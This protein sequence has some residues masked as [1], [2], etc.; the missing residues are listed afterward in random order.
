MN[1][2]LIDRAVDLARRLQQRASGLQTAAERRQQSELDRM[3]QTPTDKA[4]LVQ[5]TD[6][7]FRPRHAARVAEQITHILDVQGVPRFFNPVDRALMR[8]FQTFGGWLP[9]VA[10][11][12]V[13][14]QMRQETANVVLPAETE[15]LTKHLRERALEGVRMNL[16]FLGEALLGESEAQHR[17]EKYLAALQLPEVE[18]MSVKISTIFSQINPLGRADTLRVLCERLE[19]LFRAAARARYT[20]ADGTQVAKFVYLDMEEYRDLHL[21]AVAFMRTLDRPGLEQ[22][23]AGVALQ[24][25]I[26]DSARVHRVINEWARKRVAAGGSP[27]TVRLV[28]GANMEMERVEA[29]LRDWPQVTFKRKVETDANYKR[30]LEEAMRPENLTAVC[31]G[32]ASHNLFDLALGLVLAE[33]AKAGDKVQFEMLEGMA[34]HQRRALLEHSR[35]LLLYAPA[36]KREEFLNA[37]GYLIRR[38]DENTGPDNFLRHAFKLSVGSPEWTQLETGFRAAFAT[39]FSDAPRRTQD[40]NTEKFDEPIAEMTLDRFHNEPDTDWSLPQNSA[41]A[42]KL[43]ARKEPATRTLPCVIAGVELAPEAK[44]GVCVDPSRPGVEV[45]CYRLGTEADVLRP[46]CGLHRPDRRNRSGR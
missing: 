1:Q 45:A 2:T 16:N 17:L 24:A 9:G 5:L 22:V 4:T 19:L 34:N 13:K 27:I 30:M 42:E 43:I 37:I 32:V 41:W 31:V 26:P 12:M 38:L 7:A 18:V 8:G 6:Q 36:C 14:E 44:V 25:Y 46:R 3:L 40:R 29:S 35:N 10:V 20:R 39:P 33:A 23:R 15:H 21:T 11:P 28:K